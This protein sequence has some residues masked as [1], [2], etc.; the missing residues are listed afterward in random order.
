MQKAPCTSD[1]I[2][3]V[4]PNQTK[5]CMHFDYLHNH[6]LIIGKLIVF[7][8]SANRMNVL[9]LHRQLLQS[10]KLE[11]KRKITNTSLAST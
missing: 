3:C 2:Y 4:N 7:V 5:Y 6:L 8:K 10:L 1:M 9:S 11:T